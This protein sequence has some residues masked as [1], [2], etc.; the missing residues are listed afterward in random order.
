MEN[1]LIR[2]DAFMLNEIIEGYKVIKEV[3]SRDRNFKLPA[4][5]Y[6]YSYAWIPSLAQGIVDYFIESCETETLDESIMEVM[7]NENEVLYYIT[8]ESIMSE[9]YELYL[10]DGTD[11]KY[12]SCGKCIGCNELVEEW[13]NYQDG[14]YRKKV[15]FKDS[16]DLISLNYS[17]YYLLLAIIEDSFCDI[18]T[19]I[20]CELVGRSELEV[21]YYTNNYS[22]NIQSFFNNSDII[23]LT[24]KLLKIK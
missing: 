14:V 21:Y 5:S 16:V 13:E 23:Y 12:C 11:K 10:E 4:Y 1:A 8:M 19:L 24:K 22:G 9:A 15:K 6:E 20:S 2:I 3:S 7:K 17:D 18:N